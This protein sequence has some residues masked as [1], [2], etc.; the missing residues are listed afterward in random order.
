MVLKHRSTQLEALFV[1]AIAI[2]VAIGVAGLCSGTIGAL[3]ELEKRG[4]D[5]DGGADGESATE[6][7]FSWWNARHRPISMVL[8]I[9]HR[10]GLITAVVIAAMG[11]MHLLQP[12][13]ATMAALTG[14]MTLL[15]VIV[16]DV[17]PVTIAKNHP[18]RFARMA[19]RAIR[20]PYLLLYPVTQ[21]L[22]VVRR[23]LR[24]L[25]GGDNSGTEEGE[26]ARDKI[27]WRRFVGGDER[28][29]RDRRRLMRSVV[30]FPTIMVREVMIP[31]TD[32][33]VISKEMELDEIL[34][35]L[36]E[37]G[38]SR[39]PVHGETLDEIEGLFYAKDVIQLM[40]SGRDFEI[41]ELL[42]RP[43]FV[44]ETKPISELLT[45]FQRER[46]HLAVV[47]DE[48]GGT[49]GLITLEDI[50]EEFFGDIQ[51]EY[52][53]EPA[54]LIELSSTAVVADARIG[55]DEI[56]EFFDV[57]LP[58]SGEYDSLGGFLLEQIGS[59]PSIGEEIRWDSLLFRVTEAN[60]KRIDT[61]Q[62]EWVETKPGETTELVS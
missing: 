50:I 59:V 39:I 23:A 21:F 20:L 29:S 28:I 12:G 7:A 46:I 55:I 33:V 18:R 6:S 45:E 49:A 47:V 14:A 25:F 53:V 58:R 24:R 30:E 54:Q 11:A 15:A 4:I 31:R 8:A 56:E 3:D 60:V 43:H 61:V 62:V 2:A 1:Q 9:G 19:L 38:H 13:L 40:A 35:I 37:C 36:L 34:I 22:L 48:F 27:A 57:Q 26:R 10:L 17:V 32:M 16:T 41:D 44:P 52:D 5:V 42:R 51:D